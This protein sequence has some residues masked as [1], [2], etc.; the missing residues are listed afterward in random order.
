MMLNSLQSQTSIGPMYISVASAT[1]AAD[2]MDAHPIQRNI[3]EIYHLGLCS[4]LIL[5]SSS[6]ALR[7]C[8]KERKINY[9]T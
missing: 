8:L 5:A 2:H 3:V 7:G 4:Q 6:R 9:Q 1:I